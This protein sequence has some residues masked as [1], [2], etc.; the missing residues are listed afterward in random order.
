LIQCA[1]GIIREYDLEL[2]VP[3]VL[4]IQN[5]TQLRAACASYAKKRGDEI[6]KNKE[7]FEVIYVH[8]SG[9]SGKSTLCTEYCRQQNLSFYITDDGDPMGNY[10][11]EDC[12]ILD[13]FRSSTMSYHALLK[14]LDSRNR[15]SATARYRNKLFIG[16]KIFI[17]S[18]LPL[19]KL[20]VGVQARN[21]ED[22]NLTQLRRRI[23]NI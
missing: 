21:G 5:E 22:K 3:D 19:D 8:G 4:R 10:R 15:S 1:D 7:T 11:G 12:I 14:F 18:P 9:G 20:Y 6:V 13:D 23:S 16:E 17:T 2:K